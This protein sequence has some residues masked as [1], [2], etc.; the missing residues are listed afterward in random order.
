MLWRGV[1]FTFFFLYQS[2]ISETIHLKLSSF[3]E[4][5]RSEFSYWKL[6]KLWRKWNTDD[7]IEESGMNNWGPCIELN[8]PS[9]I[10]S[11]GSG[12]EELWVV[13]HSALPLFCVV[14]AC[15]MTLL[16][17]IW[18]ILKREDSGLPN[19]FTIW[20]I[21]CLFHFQKII[22]K[23]CFQER[24]QTPPKHFIL[25]SYQFTNWNFTTVAANTRRQNLNPPKTPICPNTKFQNSSWCDI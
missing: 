1:I 25:E 16:H 10:I 8:M 13:G 17:L 2:F 5:S 14:A 23:S 24:Y 7:G 11:S 4:G 9:C 12:I 21:R 22:L 15:F 6:Q 18:E 20:K 19:T 3:Y